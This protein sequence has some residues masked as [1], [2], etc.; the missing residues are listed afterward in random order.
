MKEKSPQTNISKERRAFLKCGIASTL[1]LGAA[2]VP[3]KAATA[4]SEDQA[5]QETGLYRET[6]HIRQYYKLARF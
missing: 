3:T 4:A 1:S 5:E 6:D 2:I